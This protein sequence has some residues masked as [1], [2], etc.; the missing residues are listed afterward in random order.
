M[1][2]DS[3]QDL[4]RHVRGELR[5]KGELGSFLLAELDAAIAHGSEERPHRSPGVDRE[6]SQGRRPLDEVELVEV[7]AGVLTTYLVT[8]PATIRSLNENLRHHGQ[9]SGAEIAVD[10]TLL[11]EELQA[12]GRLRVD[13]IAPS[14]S[15]GEASEALDR[16]RQ[17][18][19]QALREIGIGNV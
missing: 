3:I 11:G 1:A 16:I 18:A 15:E 7:V 6:E 13:Q 9:V 14:V 4:V 10:P 12:A 5:E 8:L 19:N 2:E 17:L